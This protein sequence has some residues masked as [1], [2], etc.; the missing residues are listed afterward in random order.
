MG[1]GVG[2]KIERGAAVQLHATI[3]FWAVRNQSPCATRALNGHRFNMPNRLLAHPFHRPTLP[4]PI[5]RD[6]V[7]P[8]NWPKALS[9]MTE[10]NTL[11]LN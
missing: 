4:E 6:F 5:L 8:D 1:D 11:R 2:S 9:L 7:A 10:A 3:K